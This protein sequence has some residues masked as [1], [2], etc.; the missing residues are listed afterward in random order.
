[1]GAR[2]KSKGERSR[3]RS[4][5]RARQ[6]AA[7]VTEESPAMAVSATEELAMNRDFEF[8]QL[9]RAYRVGIISEQTFETE[10][11]ALEHGRGAN[12][13]NGT[14]GGF[15]AFGKNYASEREAVLT[16]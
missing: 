16:F 4:P 2:Q 3:R 11:A 8:K 5:A 10:M 1:M 9:L 15:R 14:A 12:G 7:I 6:A 13:S